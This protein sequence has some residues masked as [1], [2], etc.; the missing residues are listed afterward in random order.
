MLCIQEELGVLGSRVGSPLDNGLQHTDMGLEEVMDNVPPM[1]ESQEPA[2]WMNGL[3]GCL[4]PVWKIIGKATGNE[5]K[6]HIQGKNEILSCI[7]ISYASHLE[8][9]F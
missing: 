4:Q 1:D 8:K 5:L 6:G 9:E 7:M 2:G 3:L